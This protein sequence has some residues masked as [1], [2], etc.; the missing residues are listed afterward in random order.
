MKRYFIVI[1][2]IHTSDSITVIVWITHGPCRK[3]G[4][5]STGARETSWGPMETV[6]A[7]AL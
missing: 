5:I 7:P 3:A 1:L 6:W 2:V 4:A